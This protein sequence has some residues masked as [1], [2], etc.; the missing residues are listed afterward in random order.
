MKGFLLLALAAISSARNIPLVKRVCVAD[1]CSNAVSDPNTPG[2]AKCSAYYIDAGLRATSTIFETVTSS[3]TATVFEVTSTS[4]ST[5]TDW[6]TRTITTTIQTTVLGTSTV[7]LT[8]RFTSSA[9]TETA[10]PEPYDAHCADSAGFISACNCLAGFVAPTTTTI[11][12]TY[13]TT[14]TAATATSGIVALEIES[15]IATTTFTLTQTSTSATATATATATWISFKLRGNGGGHP[16][17][18]IGIA[19]T[20]HPFSPI[21]PSFIDTTGTNSLDFDLNQANG[22]LKLSGTERKARL[23]NAVWPSTSATR[24]LY[25]TTPEAEEASSIFYAERNR[26]NSSLVGC[27]LTGYGLACGVSAYTVLGWL[28]VSET[29]V[30]ATTSVS[31]TSAGRSQEFF[32]AVPYV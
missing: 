23:N 32:E 7:D 25:F 2:L 4:T 3:T 9:V 31:W 21:Y 10:V 17:E 12:V 15:A 27:T 13:T 22:V 28:D 14:E 26:P 5:N 20:G 1:D 6:P 18:Y 11:T 29:L 19:N 30:L 24:V 16:G 8:I